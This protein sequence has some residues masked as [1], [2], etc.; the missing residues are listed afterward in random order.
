DVLA[1]EEPLEIRVVTEG[2]APLALSVTMRTPGDDFELA[3]GFLFAEGIIDNRDDVLSIR[4]CVDGPNGGAQQFNIVNVHL[5]P[6]LS[7]DLAALQRNFVTN[8]SCG[9]CGKSSIAAIRGP[10]RK[11][12]RD[13][14]TVAP[15]ALLGM[16]TRLREVQKVFARTGGLHGAAL[17]RP[18]G[19][20]I[21]VRE[22]VGRHNAMDKLIGAALLEDEVPRDDAVLI[23]SGR[24]SFELVQKAVRAGVPFLA[25]VSAPSSLA[26]ELAEEFGMTLVGFLR[27]NRFNIYAGSQRISHTADAEVKLC[28]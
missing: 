8:S 19:Q 28:C 1:T 11:L 9:I 26:V 10:L 7:I 24:L 4:Y 18:D 22:D 6:D 3:A 21:R 16:H 25:G 27:E 2:R 15:A 5:A 14:M 23:V 17:F 20:F 12:G 13:D